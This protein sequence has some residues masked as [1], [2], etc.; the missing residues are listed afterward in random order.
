MLAEPM[1]ILSLFPIRRSP[2]QK[3]SF[4]NAVSAYAA[5]LGYPVAVEQ[6]K[7]GVHNVIIGDPKTAKFLITA[8]YDTPAVSPFPNFLTPTNLPVYVLYQI[9][10]VLLFIAVAGLIC[11]P[12]A[13][14]SKDRYITFLVWYVAY[15]VL[16]FLPRYGPANRNNSN[17]NTSGIVT[18]LETARSMPQN[19]RHKVCFVLFDLEEKGLVGSAAYRKMHKDETEKQIVL[20]LDCV[21]DGDEFLIFPT[22]KLKKDPDAMKLLKRCCGRFGKKSIALRQKGSGFYPSDQKNFPY[23][24]AIAAFRRNQW[25][26]LYHSR[27][28]TAKDT[29]L[30]TTNINILRAALITLVCQ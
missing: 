24:A 17:D 1:D 2:A 12:A 13:I 10:I 22:K 18:L 3:Q 27:I 26:G 30:E 9:F 4:R 21:G 23:G 7:R 5:T 14:I 15:M 19:Q 6:S 16:A 28:H 20:N 11:L 29:V 8:H 25:V